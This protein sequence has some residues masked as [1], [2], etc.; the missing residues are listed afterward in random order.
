MNDPA[1][2]L[3]K[4]SYEAQQLSSHHKNI[5]HKTPD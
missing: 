1:A 3:Y 4:A 2:T 5:S